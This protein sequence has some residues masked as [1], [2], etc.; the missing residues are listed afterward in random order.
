MPASSCGYPLK[1][2]WCADQFLCVV[3]A[4]NMPIEIH[5]T[6]KRYPTLGEKVSSIEREIGY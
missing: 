2:K 3:Q 5:I 1:S 4:G 6:S